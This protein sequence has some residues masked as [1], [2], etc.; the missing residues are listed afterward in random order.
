MRRCFNR[1]QNN[2][3]GESAICVSAFGVGAVASI[4]LFRKFIL[5]SAR[6]SRAANDALVVGFFAGR[7]TKYI[8]LSSARSVRREGAPNCARGGRAPHSIVLRSICFVLVIFISIGFLGRS[9]RA[10]G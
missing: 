1:R 8:C 9:R 6:A 7:A 10:S 3:H 2:C 4:Y 5:G